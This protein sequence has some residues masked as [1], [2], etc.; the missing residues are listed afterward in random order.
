EFEKTQSR[1][2]FSW[3]KFKVS[4]LAVPLLAGAAVLSVAAGINTAAYYRQQNLAAQESTRIF[5]QGDDYIFSARYADP[6]I[7]AKVLPALKQWYLGAH[8]TKAL[9]K[10]VSVLARSP[11]PKADLVLEALFKRASLL[12]LSD[13]GRAELVRALVDRSD[14]AMFSF[15]KDPLM[16]ENPASAALFSQA[17]AE[18]MAHG[19]DK[20]KAAVF[21]LLKSPDDQL[22]RAAAQSIYSALTAPDQD[23]QFFKHLI[24]IQAQFQNDPDMNMW[25]EVFALERL[26]SPGPVD[27]GQAASV[28]KSVFAAL[29]TADQN[30][31][32]NL[33]QAQQQQQPG[34]AAAP[35]NFPPSY[36]LAALQ[37]IQQAEAAQAQSGGV[38]PSLATAA[39]AVIAQVAEGIIKNG[40]SALGGYNFHGKLISAGVEDSNAPYPYIRSYY[41]LKNL[42]DLYDILKA[43]GKAS[44]SQD[45]GNS[46]GSQYDYGGGDYSTY[47]PQQIAVYLSNAEGQL[48]VMIPLGQASGMLDGAAPGEKAAMTVNAALSSF[49]QSGL[50]SNGS[51][52]YQSDLSAAFAAALKAQGLTSSDPMLS[53][54]ANP[55]LP[56]YTYDQ[57]AKL[58]AFVIQMADQGGLNGTVPKSDGAWSMKTSA[59]QLLAKIDGAMNDDFPS[60]AEAAGVPNPASADYAAKS[61]AD[62]SQAGLVMARLSLQE[63]AAQ[64]A[65]DRLAVINLVAQR[66][67]DLGAIPDGTRDAARV[68]DQALSDL[69]S[70]YN[71]GGSNGAQ[72]R[73]LSEAISILGKAAQSRLGAAPAALM[74]HEI[75][76]AFNILLS[77]FNTNSGDVYAQLQTLGLISYNYDSNSSNSYY[78]IS[79]MRAMLALLNKEAP[80]VASGSI[81]MGDLDVSVF[82]ET[83]TVLPQLIELA[84]K[85][86]VAEGTSAADTAA[87]SI[88]NALQTA[89]QSFYSDS[90]ALMQAL[91]QAGL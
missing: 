21:S 3:R 80:K 17:V 69:G 50:G 54:Q 47:S 63:Q 30:N 64:T 28:M 84:A 33:G 19:G 51:S 55:W 89:A 78:S 73:A 34:A 71:Q 60:Q 36:V 57:L 87:V 16:L 1:R 23:A 53:G 24:D 12:P 82:K 90:D 61:M 77:Y 8:S 46:D 44:P 37:Q 68:I 49:A 35:A 25:V 52:G 9:D 67:P 59:I 88:N 74:R 40:E 43:E 32:Q 76:S 41:Y 31:L 91:R 15:F 39:R 6:M 26:T 48:Q 79:Q 75:E 14:P 38:S 65:Q 5:Y 86:G 18:T 7:E 27:A 81:D 11:D 45:G 10:A 85:F 83:R 13:Q 42:R 58:R 2:T 72:A 29:S 56:A 4:L 70:S 66:I 20:M 22:R 62:P